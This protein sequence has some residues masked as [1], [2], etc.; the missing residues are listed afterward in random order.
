MLCASR[1]VRSEQLSKE[2]L[3][4]FF[5]AVVYERKAHAVSGT[6]KVK[7][8][9]FATNFVT[10][11]RGFGAIID[12]V[13]CGSSHK[14]IPVLIDSLLHG[15]AQTCATQDPIVMVGILIDVRKTFAKVHDSQARRPPG[16]SHIDHFQLIDSSTHAETRGDQPTWVLFQWLNRPCVE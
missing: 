6:V 15:L 9:Q 10:R 7:V 1:Q 8:T 13:P 4:F 3:Y 5:Q 2:Y 16:T 12:L 11:S 14:A